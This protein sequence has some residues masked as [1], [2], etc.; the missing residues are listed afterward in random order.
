MT[1]TGNEC[2][3][4]TDTRADAVQIAVFVV[5]SC[6]FNDERLVQEEKIPVETL[7]DRPLVWFDPFFGR[8]DG[9]EIAICEITADSFTYALRKDGKTE[10]MTTWGTEY[11]SAKGGNGCF[12]SAHVRISRRS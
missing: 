7:K 12:P 9:T 4:V 1:K 2:C 5:M 6:N 3:A 11:V 8:G 10:R